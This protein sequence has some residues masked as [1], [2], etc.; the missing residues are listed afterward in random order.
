MARVRKKGR[1]SGE[2]EGVGVFQSIGD[3]VAVLAVVIDRCH[4]L[5]SIREPQTKQTTV[6]DESVR[7]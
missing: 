6:G 5:G 1:N 7:G 3:E 4:R 2:G